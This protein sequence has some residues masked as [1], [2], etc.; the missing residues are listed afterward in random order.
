MNH[1]RATTTSAA[2]RYLL[3][4]MTAEEREEFEE[5]YFSCAECAEDMRAAGQLVEALRAT[6]AV[7]AAITAEAEQL[8]QFLGNPATVKF[9]G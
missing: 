1:Q 7:R 8:G 5:H 9:G 3:D 2:E 6:P 4:E